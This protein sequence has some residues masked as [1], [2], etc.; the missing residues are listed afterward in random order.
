MVSGVC[1]YLFTS[2][3]GKWM[4]I[5]HNDARYPVLESI[6]LF[7]LYYCTMEVRFGGQVCSFHAFNLQIEESLPLSAQLLF[8]I[9]AKCNSQNYVIA[10]T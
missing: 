8:S 4:V 1:L 5:Y 7:V 6:F 9:I 3:G 2:F 10:G